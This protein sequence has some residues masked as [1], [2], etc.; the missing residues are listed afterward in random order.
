MSACHH[1]TI[2]RSDVEGHKRRGR[3][4]RGIVYSSSTGQRPEESSSTRD[5][6]RQQIS[7]RRCTLQRGRLLSTLPPA[8]VSIFYLARDDN[9]TQYNNVITGLRDPVIQRLTS[10]LQKVKHRPER[11]A[12]RGTSLPVRVRSNST[13]TVAS[14]RRATSRTRFTDTRESG[15]TL[16][17][18]SSFLFDSDFAGRN[19]FNCKF[20][21]LHLHIYFSIIKVI[22]FFKSSLR[23]LLIPNAF[24][25]F[26]VSA[27]VTSHL[28]T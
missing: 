19:Q 18:E 3:E 27:V 26:H 9:L 5:R 22:Y 11:R 14:D 20:I 12:W 8:R 6:G 21:L 25:V 7:E 2:V 4:Q 16:A 17:G 24:H 13:A 15:H 1:H 23:R 28:S 10:A